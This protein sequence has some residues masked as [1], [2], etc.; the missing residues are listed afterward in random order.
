MDDIRSTFRLAIDGARE[1]FYILN[2]ELDKSGNI[3]RVRI[4]D[5][6]EHAAKIVGR[7]RSALLGKQITDIFF[8]DDAGQIIALLRRSMHVELIEDELELHGDTLAEKGW[9][10]FRAVR[11]ST[12]IAV[13]VRNISDIKE[14]EAQELK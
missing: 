8:D 4:E 13:T 1:A 9:F 11:S 6:N 10:N 2:P 14:K 12:G 7:D 5:C 3:V